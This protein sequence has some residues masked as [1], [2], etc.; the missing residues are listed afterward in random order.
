MPGVQTPLS[1][2]MI[3]LP[4]KALFTFSF[5]GLLISSSIVI[6]IQNTAHSVISLICCFFFASFFLLLLECEFFAF[7]F[8]T[9]Y[10]GAIAVLFLFVVMMLN[11]K[12]IMVS[13]RKTT[14]YLIFGVLIGFNF[15]VFGFDLIDTLFCDF[16]VFEQNPEL[17]LN[18]KIDYHIED[19]IQEIG[20][21][22]QVLYTHFVLQ[23]LVSG[24]ILFLA[25]IGVVGITMDY[26]KKP[27]FKGIKQISRN[28]TPYDFYFP[29]DFRKI[30]AKEKV[31]KD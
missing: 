28:L 26:S 5:I 10:I 15:V 23:F 16:Q 4:L 3:N 22:G 9:I 27:P 20:V 13:R 7:I 14:K 12:F 25:V 6:I 18:Y 1:L 17:F 11:T 21:L 29:L 8:L 2:I 31:K 30:F 19:N 24:L